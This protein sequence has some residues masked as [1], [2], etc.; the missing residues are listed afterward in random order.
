MPLIAVAVPVPFLDLLTYHVPSRMAVPPV[1]A[2]VRVPLGSRV[3]TGCVVSHDADIDGESESKDVVEVLD[4]DPFLPA[5]VVDLCRWVA[6]YYMA[7]IG[8]AIGV[9]MPPGARARVSAFRTRRVVA[10]S[11]HGLELIRLNA[12]SRPV[13]GSDP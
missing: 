7:G 6:D 8:D 4:N 1:G 10:A 5:S 9:A 2:R 13:P 3:V 12:L 11:A